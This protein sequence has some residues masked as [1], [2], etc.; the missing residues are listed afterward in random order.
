MISAPQSKSESCARSRVFCAGGARPSLQAMKRDGWGRVDWRTEEK[1]HRDSNAMIFSKDH[2]FARATCLLAMGRAKEVLKIADEY[3][4]NEDDVSRLSGYLCRGM[5]Y[6]IGGEGVEPD[7]EKSMDN[8]RRVS[9][10]SPCSAAFIDL[11]RV[12]MKREGG[13]PDARRFLNVALDYPLVAETVLC[14]AEYYETNPEPDVVAARQCYAKV[15]WMWRLAGFRGYSR[16]S[17]RMGLEREA[18]AVS[19]LRVIV[20]PLLLLLVGN[21]ARWTF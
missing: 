18:F 13:Y 1:R 4:E 14:L 10:I 9:L 2:K 6:E 17:R 19:V 16:V 3:L 8:Y 5:V 20:T 15:A 11:A 21:R 12:S 7:L